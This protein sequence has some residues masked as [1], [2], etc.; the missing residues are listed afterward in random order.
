[1]LSY[2]WCSLGAFIHLSVDAN[3]AS[4]CRDFCAFWANDGLFHVEGF[5]S[6]LS[7]PVDNYAP[8][9]IYLLFDLEAVILDQNARFADGDPEKTKKTY[10]TPSYFRDMPFEQIYHD[11]WFSSDEREE[12]MRHREAQVIWNIVLIIQIGKAQIHLLI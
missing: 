1:M 6:G 3:R 10:K 5:R 7:A 2:G 4:E 11:S 8:I 12:I 9:P